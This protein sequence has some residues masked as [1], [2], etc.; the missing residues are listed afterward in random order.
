MAVGA[1]L[2][3]TGRRWVDGSLRREAPE[4]K[5]RTERSERWK[6]A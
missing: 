3:P 1:E 5:A 6:D 4:R 2:D